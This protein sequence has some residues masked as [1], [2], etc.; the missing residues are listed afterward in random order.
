MV[1]IMIEE[2]RYLVENHQKM[3]MKI[4]AK[5]KNVSNVVLDK[6]NVIPLIHLLRLTNK[7]RLCERFLR[8]TI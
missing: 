6:E 8:T 5:R 3:R 1:E 2:M 4:H 7:V